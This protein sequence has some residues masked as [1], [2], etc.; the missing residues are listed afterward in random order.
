MPFP[1]SQHWNCISPPSD[2]E[3]S[4]NSYSQSIRD[5]GRSPNDELEFSF[6]DPLHLRSTVGVPC[7]YTNTDEK[8]Q[9]V[10]REKEPLM[11][12]SPSHCN[13]QTRDGRDMLLYTPVKFRRSGDSFLDPMSGCRNLQHQG[14]Q[15]PGFDAQY[16]R[17]GHGVVV[18]SIIQPK[19][20][21][22]NSVTELPSSSS[23]SVSSDETEHPQLK[24]E[25]YKTELCRSWEE[26]GYCRYAA[27]CQVMPLRR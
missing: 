15:S 13:F 18:P 17:N 2:E 1:Y 24:V 16:F 19:Q 25:L 27:K 9:R 7:F 23:V 6:S 26:T 3:F 5:W 4:Y 21:I 20:A 14:S 10:S 12:S 22:N 11:V 8:F